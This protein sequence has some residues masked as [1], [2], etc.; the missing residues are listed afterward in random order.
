MKE[1]HIV[2]SETTHATFKAR[3]KEA[4]VTHDKYL[5]LLLA[6]NEPDKKGK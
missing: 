2:V 1:K 6:C 4:G 3:A 5:R